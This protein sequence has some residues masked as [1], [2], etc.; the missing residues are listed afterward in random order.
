VPIE[1]QKSPDIQSVVFP[2]FDDNPQL[3]SQYLDRINEAGQFV[4]R[5]ATHFKAALFSLDDI[6]KIY[7]RNPVT[8]LVF[9]HMLVEESS[10][11]HRSSV[12][13]GALDT[14][15]VILNKSLISSLADE[16]VNDAVFTSINDTNI[17]LTNPRNNYFRINRCLPT[18]QSFL[19]WINSFNPK[20]VLISNQ[21]A[22]D[23]GQISDHIAGVQFYASQLFEYAYL[24][25]V[26]QEEFLGVFPVTEC[27]TLNA[28]TE[29]PAVSYALI[30]LKQDN[31]IYKTVRTYDTTTSDPDTKHILVSNDL[32]PPR[33][34]DTVAVDSGT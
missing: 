18:G 12:L 2:A 10:G 14:N 22:V 31:G 23:Q 30:R 16:S 7:L 25:G 20:S 28:N 21:N 3:K 27:L 8:H 11:N 15:A 5:G 26:G 1:I 17:I 6:R 34:I 13:C 4:A 33:W 24:D 19:E 29:I 9:S 32:W